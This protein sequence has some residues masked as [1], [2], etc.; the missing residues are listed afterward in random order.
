M[1]ARAH[2]RISIFLALLMLLA[3]LASCGSSNTQKPSPST[4]EGTTEQTE[5][6]DLYDENGY[7]RDDL[8]ET[9]DL[10]GRKFNIYLWSEQKQWD[11]VDTSVYPTTRLDQALYS[12]E[13]NIEER[14]NIDINVI[15]EPGNW[16]YRTA[17]IQKLANSVNLNDQAY[18]LVGQYT[19]AVGIG[20]VQGLYQNLNAVEN[21]N[22]DKPWWPKHIVSSSTVGGKVYSLTGDISATLIRN[23]Q[24]MFVNLDLYESYNIAQYDSENRSIY[25]IVR[26]YDWTLETMKQLALGHVG[27][28]DGV[29]EN[30]KMYGLS[31]INSVAPDAFLYAGGFKM[32][33]DDDGRIALS[34]DLSSL[35]F[36]DW[37]DSVHSLFDGKTADIYYKD[38]TGFSV[39]QGNRAI[40]YTG[41]VSESQTLA[42][43]GV[44]FSIL[45][46]PMRDTAQGDY[47][48]CASLWVTMFSV[49]VDV[50]DSAMSGFL[51]EALASESYRTVT[52]EVYYNIFQARYNSVGNK[53]SAE[54]FDIVSDSVVFD[55]GR[56]FA[57]ALKCFALFRT[58]INDPDGQWSTVYATNLPAL[59]GYITSLI[60]TIG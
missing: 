28:D 33:E 25:D 47:Y 1:K 54:M 42:Q 12:R 8:P 59:K 37:Y 34:S 14:F 20:V 17:F 10:E 9:A 38:S 44:Q 6:K 53:D 58:A 41:N 23:V 21:I 15:T 26:D 48:T 30:E 39:F 45:P 19:A 32:I 2:S 60:A 51:M 18:D 31:I 50:A 11:F 36:S 49:P 29:G 55:T 35:S 46:M 56:I 7:L 43:K 13:L 24:S 40:F 5:T 27:L 57:D 3:T 16:D 52:A 22:T 4:T